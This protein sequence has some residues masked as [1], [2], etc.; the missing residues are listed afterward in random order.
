MVAVTFLN[1]DGSTIVASG[2]EG[3]TLMELAREVGIDGVLGDCGGGLAC[4]T[5]HVHVAADWLDRAGTASPAEREMLDMA[6]EP[7]AYS[8]LMEV[9]LETGLDEDA[10]YE[11]RARWNR[12]IDDVRRQVRQ[13]ATACD[14]DTLCKLATEFL[15]QL[16]REAIAA[17]SA[18]Y[19]RG[20]RLD[21]VI[22]QT[23]DRI[24]ELIALDADPVGALSQFTEDS[25]VRI[26]TIHKS[27]GLEFDT[28]ILLGVEEQAFFGKRT[29]ERSAFFVGISR[30]KQRLYLTVAGYRE[31]P[32]AATRR[33][34]EV[35]SPVEEFLG[36]ATSTA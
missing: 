33:W 3:L 27:K 1:P 10:A 14:A 35:R 25:A 9:L 16:G 5:C 29:D 20:S 30:A 8:R 32:P 26:M 4:A 13:G 21:D 28:A 19:E 11:Q 24:F 6:V 7:D 31:K 17:L 36:Y 34:D 23:Q 12:H 22:A 2:A 15:A 18:D